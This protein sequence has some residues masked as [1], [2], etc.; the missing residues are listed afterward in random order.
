M[1][2]SKNRFVIS[3]LPLLF[4]WGC[5]D[6]APEE[7]SNNA[8]TGA[9]GN[10]L[11]TGGEGT[12]TDAGGSGGVPGGGGSG[13]SGGTPASGGTGGTPATETGGTSGSGGE[14][15]SGGT[16]GAVDDRPPAGPEGTVPNDPQ[17]PSTVG[18]TNS[19][20]P[21]G[22]ISDTLEFGHHNQPSIIN[23]YLQLTG[24]AL[25]AMYDISDPTQPEQLSFRESPGHCAHCGEA[26]GHQVSFAKYGDTFYAATINGKGIDIW[27]VTDARDPSH[28]KT[29]EIAGVNYGD[30]TEAVWGIAWQGTTIFVG[31]T[32]T[33]LHVIDAGDPGNASV[34]K[35]VPQ[36]QLGNVNAGPLF[37]VGNLLVITTPKD[38]AGIATLDI[39]DPHNPMI[40][41]SMLPGTNSYIGWFYR[42]HIYLLNPIRVYDVLSDPTD[43]TQINGNRPGGY[44]EYMSFQDGYMF[45]GRI[46]PNPGADKIDVSDLS[47]FTHESSIIGRRDLSGNAAPE[48]DDQF[49]VAVGNLLVLS[50]DQ[51][52]TTGPNS[53]TYAGTVIAVHDTEPDTTPPHVD[54]IIPR[55][56]ST[57]QAVTTRVGIS[58]T[59]NVELA[60]VDNRSF[61]V[62][63][64]GGQALEGTFSVTMS[65]LNFEPA[66]PLQPGTTYEVVLPAGGVKDYVGNGVEE[67]TSTFTTQ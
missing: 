56:G 67:F 49:T 38:N 48:N 2:S 47:N 59:D 1:L 40:L 4:A 5:S 19:N 60:T 37:A 53:G 61:I 13:A 43:I 7:S 50:D 63:P 35:S 3:S 39:S 25:L 32:N 33:G 65:V 20:W 45:A 34:V 17:D 31:G 21:D 66:E 51:L 23:G 29:I 24:N 16:G 6:A 52:A 46:R 12:Q 41:D 10:A 14:G 18:T 44:W 62:R 30:F 26:E 28:V 22:L 64:Q 36:G 42:H 11:S 9:G 55:D 57:G 54:T 15:T 8:E 58:F 27:N